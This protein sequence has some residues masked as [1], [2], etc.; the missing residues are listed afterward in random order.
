[1][2]PKSSLKQKVE[3]LI[4]RVSAL[5]ESFEKNEARI[6]ENRAGIGRLEK[7]IKDLKATLTAF[8]KRLRNVENAIASLNSQLP[9]LRDDISKLRSG[10]QSMKEEGQR[11]KGLL[12]EIRKSQS[13]SEA[14]LEV[15]KDSVNSLGDFQFWIMKSALKRIHD[16]EYACRYID[17]DG[18]C[19]IWEWPQIPKHTRPESRHG[20]TVYRLKHGGSFLTYPVSSDSTTNHP[21]G[22]SITSR[23]FSVT[24]PTVSAIDDRQSS[25]KACGSKPLSCSS[26]FSWLHS[27]TIPLKT[28]SPA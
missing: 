14:E 3:E 16:E 9:S 22:I 7:S 28:S 5:E 8:D 23:T 6:N 15:I 1:V 19:S 18:C 2:N 17:K 10:L 12:E 26:V 24:C 25:R 4:N 20:K 27:Q 21:L 13:S 11:I